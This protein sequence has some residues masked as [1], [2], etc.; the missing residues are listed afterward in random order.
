MDR[1]VTVHEL[2]HTFGLYHAHLL[3]CVEAGSEVTL[4][5][6]GCV[7]DEYG[8][9]FDAMGSSS[10]VGHFSAAQ[11][12]QLGW[13]AGADAD[14]ASSPIATLGPFE[15]DTGA[16]VAAKLRL[17]SGRTYYFEYRRAVGFDAD[18][19]AGDLDGVLVHLT[20]DRYAQGPELL[21]ERSAPA[22]DAQDATLPFDKPWT[23]PEGWTITAAAV[24]GGVRL[25]ATPP[26]PPPN[27]T[28]ASA[29]PL[30][31]N[32]GFANGNTSG[33]TR[34][35]GEPLI[36]GR[37]GGTSIWYRFQAPVNGI[38]TLDTA[39]STV[40]TLLGLYTGASVDALTLVADNDDA[41]PNFAS[42][43][44][45]VAVR[46]GATYSV[47]IDA[48]NAAAGATTLNW[49]FVAAPTLAVND[50]SVKEGDVGTTTVTFI[51]TR[52]GPLTVPSSIDY[53]TVNGSA[54]AAQD[55]VAVPLRTLT[56]AVGERTKAVPVLVK[57]DRKKEKR[58]NFFL[59]LSGAT[60][61]TILDPTGAAVITDND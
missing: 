59:S 3:Q 12:D 5:A 2:G 49:S 17:S 9:A 43:V 25:T 7:T 60:A 16:P 29:T 42:R 15:R 30:T 57:G 51:V 52:A 23:I 13:L 46:K 54:T 48:Y 41:L 53:R 50:V 45:P 37:S 44:G 34:E 6:S 39:G 19:P 35:N 26:P 36:A 38:L 10:A 33:A 31:G 61:A 40:D 55:Y 8:D 24:D 56:F 47:A 1:R 21:D 58:E 22:G 18:L 11:K 14:L 32:A 20:D 27:D 4:A 28:W